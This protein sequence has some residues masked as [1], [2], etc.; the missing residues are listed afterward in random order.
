TPPTPP[1]LPATSFNVG[2]DGV[3]HP[4]WMTKG[5]VLLY[6][7]VDA[8][9]NVRRV[10][11]D[12]AVHDAISSGELGGYSYTAFG[13]TISASEPG[14]VAV[15]LSV[16]QPFGW[17]GKRLIAPNLYDSRARVWSADLGAFLQP[18]EY[19]FL[20]RGGTLWSW[21]GQNPFRWRDPSGRDASAIADWISRQSWIDE[22]APALAEAG[23][24]SGI[25]PLVAA[26]EASLIA[27]QAINAIA[28]L[29]AQR[30]SA[31]AIAKS[32]SNVENECKDPA[33]KNGWRPGPN[34][35]D[36]R[37]NGQDVKDALD[38]AFQRTGVPRE[39]FEVTRWGHDENGKSFPTEW[40][41]PGGAEVNVDLGH[42][43][44]GPGTPHVG[45]QT[46]GSRSSGGAERGHILVDDVP[47]NR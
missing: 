10:H 15:P 23:V 32:T 36:W 39:D 6:F 29:E 11:T 42:E 33:E 38:E 13:K 24:A 20:S 41:A 16:A 2:Y 8:V 26:G 30:Q 27:M 43:N 37:G 12:A 19:V 14:G 45:W 22:L 5:S 25:A 35:L 9:G 4:L 34:D 46:P 21:P 47:Y 7:E 1:D 3:D 18:D 31:A 40:R 44:Y 28:S 17:Q